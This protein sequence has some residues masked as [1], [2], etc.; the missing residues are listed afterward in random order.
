MSWK[1]TD[2]LELWKTSTTLPITQNQIKGNDEIEGSHQQQPPAPVRI[3][4]WMSTKQIDSKQRVDYFWKLI[5]AWP[6]DWERRAIIWSK[7]GI[8]ITN[9][10]TAFYIANKITAD[11]F[12][13]DPK[14]NFFQIL[15]RIPAKSP[16]LVFALVGFVSQMLTMTF[17][18]YPYLMFEGQLSTLNLTGRAVSL[19]LGMGML[20]PLFSIPPIANSAFLKHREKLGMRKLPTG[21][22]FDLIAQTFECT[23]SVWRKLPVIAGINVAGAGVVVCSMAW[24]RNRIHS[25]VDIDPELIN[26]LVINSEYYQNQKRGIIGRKLYSIGNW[27]TNP[28]FLNFFEKKRISAP[29]SHHDI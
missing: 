28:K 29:D 1:N 17:I 10:L 23:R 11:V 21:S 2:P 3:R 15:R 27:L 9:T 22:V 7:T 16:F 14:L 18:F 6:D 19:S 13:L 24:A 26:E 4:F 25:K 5:L 20:V 8:S 12:L